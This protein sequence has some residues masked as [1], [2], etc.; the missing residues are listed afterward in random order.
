MGER[1][2]LARTVEADLPNKWTRSFDNYIWTL[3]AALGVAPLAVDVVLFLQER[4]LMFGWVWSVG[5][6]TISTVPFAILSNRCL[7][8]ST[9]RARAER[10]EHLERTA[11]P[12]THIRRG[13]IVGAADVRTPV[14]TKDASDEKL[15]I[16]SQPFAIS[17]GDEVIVVDTEHIEVFMDLP[18]DGMYFRTGEKRLA[19]YVGAS[20]A[21]IASDK[22]EGRA[23]N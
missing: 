8:P 6:A 10:L 15:R 21:L 19:V 18:T 5:I 7:S 1:S 13:E 12:K 2:D 4:A 20:V 11:G 3:P 23:P 16:A 17:F 22:R 14:I 9:L